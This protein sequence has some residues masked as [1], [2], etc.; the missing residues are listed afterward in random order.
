LRRHPDDVLAR[1]RRPLASLGAIDGLPRGRHMVFGF[2]DSR[3]EV[4]DINR[5]PDT[6]G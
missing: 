4:V 5:Q 2:R 3:V 6:L 1:H